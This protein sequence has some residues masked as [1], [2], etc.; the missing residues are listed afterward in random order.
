[1]K[2]LFSLYLIFSVFFSSFIML[3]YQNANNVLFQSTGQFVLSFNFQDD[4]T[5]EFVKSTTEKL[6]AK[7]SVKEIIVHT[8]SEQYNEFIKSFSMYNQ[9][10]FES[11]E[12]THLI[13]Y[14]LDIIL[15][16]EQTAKKV[17][18]AL[19]AENIFQEVQG[20]SEWLG[21]LK[22][23]AQLTESIGRFLFLFV[24]AGTAMMTVATIRILI[25]ENEYEDKIHSYLGET[26]RS[27]YSRYIINIGG[28]YIFSV[29]MGFVLNY[30]LYRLFIFKLWSNP[31]FSFLANR[32]TYLSFDSISIMCFGFFVA[33][34]LGSF[35]SLKQ[36]FGKIYAED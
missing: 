32:L 31:Q 35:F 13:P 33:F 27:I 24:F 12:I 29:F 28:L 4:A 16:D 11:E 26:F 5:P 2:Y 14:S 21:K 9:G 25:S 19:S 18:A 22:S 1:M 23:M 7:Y 30:I 8:P 6:K 36:L 15:P 34:G 20:T 17:K 3:V 10:A